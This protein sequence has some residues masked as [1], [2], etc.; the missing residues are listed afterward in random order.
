MRLMVQK[1]SFALNF[2]LKVLAKQQLL[3]S[4]KAVFYPPPALAPLAWMC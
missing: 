4:A 1:G 2:L 3:C